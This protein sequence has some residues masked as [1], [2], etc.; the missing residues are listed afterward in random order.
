MVS[1]R[2]CC[3]YQIVE[4]GFKFKRLPEE[5]ENRLD[6]MQRKIE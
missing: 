6:E 2:V 5:E 3:C 4:S 1:E